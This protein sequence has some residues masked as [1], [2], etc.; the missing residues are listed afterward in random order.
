M[1]RVSLLLFV[2][3]LTVV[4]SCIVATTGQLPDPVATHFGHRNLPNGWMSHDGYVTFMLAFATLLPIVIV[5]IVGGL[6][7]VAPRSL[8]IPNR[9]YWLPR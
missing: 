9:E 6:P 1:H 4:T 8:N 5:G 2:L 7:H 3:L